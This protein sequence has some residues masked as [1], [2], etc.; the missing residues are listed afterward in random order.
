MQPHEAPSE[1]DTARQAAVQPIAAATPVKHG[2]LLLSGFWARGNAGD[3]AML[4]AVIETMGESFDYALSV[5]EHGAHQGFW[6]WYPY[7]GRRIVNQSQTDAILRIPDAIGLLAGGG[8]LP[9]GFGA[10]QQIYAR[11]RGLKTAIAGIDIWSMAA[12][13]GKPAAAEAGHYLGHFDR[14]YVR[15]ASSIENARLGGFADVL[16]LGADWALNLNADLNPEIGDERDRALVV[17]REDDRSVLAPDYREQ[18]R[19]LLAALWG[20]GLVPVLLPYAPE[21]EKLLEEL[22]LGRLAPVERSWWNARRLK[23]LA[24]QSG[25][26]LSIGRLHP[27]IFAAPTGRPVMTVGRPTIKAGRLAD[28][29]LR[30]MAADLG[31]D[32]HDTVAEAVLAIEAGQIRPA[33]ADKVAAAKAR[34]DA[35]ADDLRRF[36]AKMAPAR[37]A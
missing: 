27:M 21:D 18:I 33:D 5:D 15:T 16:K 4:Q 14:A 7:A 12:K 24:A 29:K 17:L 37:P 20:A 3:E 22:G 9:L 2:T 32:L 31:V 26:T 34:L 30:H 28:G 11:A 36:F 10:G 1:L 35:Q 6:D 8:G 19:R 25:L 23:Q 13:A